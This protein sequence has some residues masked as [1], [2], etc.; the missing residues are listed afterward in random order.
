MRPAISSGLGRRG[1]GYDWPEREHG[2]HIDHKASCGSAAT[3]VDVGHRR[4]K[5]VADTHC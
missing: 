5:P 4:L 3:I 2:I 1:S